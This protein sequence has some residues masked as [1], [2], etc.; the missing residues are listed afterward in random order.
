MEPQKSIDTIRNGWFR[1]RFWDIFAAVPDPFESIDTIRNTWF[2]GPVWDV[3]DDFWIPP[4][5]LGNNPPQLGS[6]PP[7]LGSGPARLGSVAPDS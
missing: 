1:G 5:S 6:D 2:R 7:Q 3:L 4:P